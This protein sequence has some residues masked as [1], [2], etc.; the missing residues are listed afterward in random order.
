VCGVRGQ[1]RGGNEFM[2]NYSP[3]EIKWLEEA[4]IIATKRLSLPSKISINLD[5]EY[6]L[7][8]RDDG[9]TPEQATNE[10]F[11]NHITKGNQ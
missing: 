3:E 11:N 5:A 7:L 10:Y 6:W 8:Y 1:G 2:S 9:L 4:R